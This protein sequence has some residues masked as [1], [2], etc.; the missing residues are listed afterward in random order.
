LRLDQTIG[1]LDDQTVLS[2]NDRHEGKNIVRGPVDP[3]FPNLPGRII[4]LT[5]INENLGRQ[6]ASGVDLNLRYRSAALAAGR[7]TLHA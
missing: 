7:F 5:E 1:Q 2:G 6:S 3:A 4:Q